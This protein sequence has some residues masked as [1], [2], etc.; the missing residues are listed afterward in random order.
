M[1]THK[2]IYEALLAY[3]EQLTVEKEAAKQIVVD[4]LTEGID[5]AIDGQ[6]E[7]KHL[8]NWAFVTTRN[9]CADYNRHNQNPSGD[10]LPA[11]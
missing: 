9:R 7:V 8:K 6:L 3:A 1:I 11:Q 10:Y 4:V 2:N 5:M